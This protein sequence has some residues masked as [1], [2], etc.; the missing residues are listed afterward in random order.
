M[1]KLG[2]MKVLPC[3]IVPDLVVECLHYN[4]I[5]F[6]GIFT[7]SFYQSYHDFFALKDNSEWGYRM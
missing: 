6:N 5:Y 1:E 3:G 7:Y 2:G 4:E